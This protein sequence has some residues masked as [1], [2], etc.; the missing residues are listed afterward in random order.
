ML[1]ETSPLR[2]ALF[3]AG[4]MGKIHAQNL[5]FHSGVE[6]A[7]VV[8]SDGEAAARLAQAHGVAAWLEDAVFSD[9]GIA[10]VVIA[11]AAVSHPH[12]IRRALASGK[13]IFCEKPLARDYETV[14]SLAAEVETARVPFL[15][16]FNRR[17]DP[18]FAAL[19]AR[20]HSGEIGKP[21][22]LVLTSRDPAPPPI[23]YVRLAGGILRETTIHDIDVARWITG[24]EP[25]SVQ[26]AGSALADPEMAQ[27]GLIDTVSLTLTMR[28]G[29]LVSINNSWRAIYGYD[30]RV[31]VLGPAGMLQV[32]NKTRHGVIRTDASGMTSANPEHFFLERYADAYRLELDAFI[33]ALRSGGVRHSWSQRRYAG[34]FNSTGCG[35]IHS[36]GFRGDTWLMMMR[37]DTQ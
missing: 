25:V 26:A 22:L 20:V 9:I 7:C 11:S 5:A 27:A 36:Y 23:D 19:A 33:V 37:K 8:D 30:Q 18:D 6:L 16:G 13:A 3:G 1:I 24:E 17:F 28:S 35:G 34:A 14:A 15:L 12:L 32:A 10:A 29:A 31:E 21:E 4:R 2:I